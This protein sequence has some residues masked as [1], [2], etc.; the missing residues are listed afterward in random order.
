VGL[1]EAS[2]DEHI[3]SVRRSTRESAKATI[4]TP[5]AALDAADTVAA[6]H[7]FFCAVWTFFFVVIMLFKRSLSWSVSLE[8]SGA[9]LSV[10][11]QRHS[12][13]KGTSPKS[14]CYLF[15]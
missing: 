13:K 14:V 7:S 8:I 15:I 12:H 11:K 5:A 3:T 10:E 9:R 6:P 2:S 1:L 4:D